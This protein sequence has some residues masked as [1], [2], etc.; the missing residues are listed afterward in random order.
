[1]IAFLIP[2]ESINKPLRDFVV[3]VDSLE[4]LTGIDF[5]PELPDSIENRLES[6]KDLSGWG[7]NK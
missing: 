2:N 4:K 7:F 1:M 3:T 6:Q 5:F